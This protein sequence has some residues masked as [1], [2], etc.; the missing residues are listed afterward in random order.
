MTQNFKRPRIH[1][2][3][4]K[5][6]FYYE[7][8]QRPTAFAPV[9]VLRIQNLPVI[10]VIAGKTKIKPILMKTCP[11]TNRYSKLWK[12]FASKSATLR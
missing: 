2:R 9:R 5:A 1:Y 11:I 6:R 4:N 3:R 7:E 12:T 8:N 10:R